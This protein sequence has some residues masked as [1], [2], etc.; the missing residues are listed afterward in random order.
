MLPHNEGTV[1]D[2]SLK[3]EIVEVKNNSQQNERY[4]FPFFLRESLHAHTTIN[5]SLP[6]NE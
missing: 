5:G 2:Q 1:I 3:I 4:M 6:Y